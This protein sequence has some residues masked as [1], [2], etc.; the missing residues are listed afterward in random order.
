M[1]DNIKSVFH[2]KGRVK[3]MEFLMWLILIPFAELILFLATLEYVSNPQLGTI[4]WLSIGLGGWYLIIVQAIKRLHDINRPGHHL[5]F[6][7]IPLYNLYF[8]IVLIFEKGTT[9]DNK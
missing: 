6:L 1:K 8:L 5:F 2:P 9:S 3:R 7:L 4:I